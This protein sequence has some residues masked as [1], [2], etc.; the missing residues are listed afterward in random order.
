MKTWTTDKYSGRWDELEDFYKSNNE[1][2]MNNNFVKWVLHAVISGALMFIP[3]F[4]GSHSA[5]L[6]VTVG[7]ALTSLYNYLLVNQNMSVG[8]TRKM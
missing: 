1:N 2:N 5:V 8:F 3:M 6:D 7:G 4:L